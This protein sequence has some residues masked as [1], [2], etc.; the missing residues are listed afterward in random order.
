MKH[1]LLQRI[2]RYTQTFIFPSANLIDASIPLGKCQKFYIEQ[3]KTSLSHFSSQI[4]TFDRSYAVF[5]GYSCFYFI[6]I[7][8]SNS[9]L[10]CTLCISGPDF[11]ELELIKKSTK[12]MLK[13]GRDICL[14]KEYLAQAYADIERDAP[15]EKKVKPMERIASNLLIKRAENSGSD[16]YESEMEKEYELSFSNVQNKPKK[17]LLLPAKTTNTTPTEKRRNSGHGSLK[18][19]NSTSNMDEYEKQTNSENTIS[20]FLISTLGVNNF[21]KLEY[22]EFTKIYLSL[23]IDFSENTEALKDKIDEV[24]IYMHLFIYL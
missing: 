22:L 9:L 2:A 23:G 19:V 18:K 24:F 3:N 7:L 21:M 15:F 10:G 1:E 4:A 16:G 13:I 17:Q 5:E 14:E 12:K 6:H 20:S 8:G 11:E